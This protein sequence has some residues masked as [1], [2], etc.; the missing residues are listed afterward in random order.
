M[1]MPLI[2]FASLGLLI[3]LGIRAREKEQAV[4]A[5]VAIVFCAATLVGLWQAWSP[6]EIVIR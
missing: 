2:W 6:W 3:L 4:L 1:V 5:V